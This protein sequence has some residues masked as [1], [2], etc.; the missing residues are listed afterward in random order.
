MNHCKSFILYNGSLTK[1]KASH[2]VVVSVLLSHFYHSIHHLN[3]SIGPLN[4]L[5]QTLLFTRSIYPKR[6]K[7]D[8]ALCAPR[9]PSPSCAPPY[10]FYEALCASM[11]PSP[12]CAPPYDFYEALC[13]PMVPSPSCAPPYDFSLCLLHLSFPVVLFLLVVADSTTDSTINKGS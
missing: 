10:D 1:N 3:E 8:E 7:L 2:N 11:V 9:V 5:I 4:T 12:S 6:L 13:A